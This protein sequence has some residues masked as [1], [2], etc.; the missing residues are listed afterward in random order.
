MLGRCNGGEMTG[1]E[2]GSRMKRRMWGEMHRAELGPRLRDGYLQLLC[3][4]GCL[5][6][7]GL[8]SK[9]WDEVVVVTCSRV[10]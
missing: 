6:V 10:C 1:F 3:M 8:G 5:Y 2:G 4:E 9:R 7:E